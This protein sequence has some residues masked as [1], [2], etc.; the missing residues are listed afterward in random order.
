MTID[1]EYPS[2]TARPV[3]VL[4]VYK[5][6][7]PNTVGGTENFISTLCTHIQNE[8]VVSRVAFLG[9]TK[10]LRLK[11]Y[12]G[13]RGMEFPMDFEFAS[14]GFSLSLLRQFN[15]ISRWA[16]I[17][18]FHFPWP[19]ADITYLASRSKKP[20]V[21]TYHSD[22]VRQKYFKLI[23]WPLM[24]WFLRRADRIVATSPNYMSTSAVL[25]RLK[26]NTQVIPL[27]IEDC[28]PQPASAVRIDY[29]RE[30]TG[31]GPFVLFVGVMRYY[32]GLHLLMEAAKDIPCSIVIVGAGPI[33]KELRNQAKKLGLKNILFTGEV[34]SAD[35]DALF[36]LCSM[37]VFPSHLR[38]EA[39]GISLLEAAM[40][41]KPLISSE[42]GTGTTYV[43]LHSETGLVVEAGNPAA[44]AIAINHLLSRPDLQKQYGDN[45]RRRFHSLF[46][47]SDMAKAYS[48]L[49]HKTLLTK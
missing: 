49:Y 47:A 22:I 4:H 6:W 34:D 36:R 29:W 37:F 13:V 25:K 35:K 41:A 1:M 9:R 12:N 18:H 2:D 15:R 3:R 28:L 46:T 40:Y 26:A 11:R 19:F 30:R 14:T 17:I 8:G 48:R 43:N 10:R 27:G 23:Y 20:L 7:S 33:E 39:F 5:T 21:I 38:S 44:L 24:F 45:A 31:G 32:K 16:D 42:I